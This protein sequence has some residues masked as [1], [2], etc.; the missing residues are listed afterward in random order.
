MWNMVNQQISDALHTSFEFTHKALLASPSAEKLYRISNDKHTFLVKVDRL[1][2]L[3]RFESEASALELMTR[4]SDFLICDP[5]TIG[6]SLDFSFI[7]LEW[8]DTSDNMDNWHECGALLAKMHQRH[9]QK[10][11]GLEQD[12][13]IQQVLQPNQWH[14]KWETFFAEDRIGWQL[15]LLAEKGIM[16][17]NIDEFVATIKTLLPHH[18]TP[19]LIHGQLSHNNI[20]FSHGKPCLF[21]PACYYGDSEVDLAM[22]ELCSALPDE[23]YQG[24]YAFQ[25]KLSDDNRRKEIYQLYPILLKANLFAGSYLHQA[26]Q[27]IHDILK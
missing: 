6:T 9:E 24:Y 7:V 17:V 19:S 2:A 13:Y 1:T 27:H 11:F 15:Q 3:E 23:F 5:I 4:D 12:N 21:N 14:K 22:A 20:A 8:L 10:M 25:N 18:I 26:K 16:L